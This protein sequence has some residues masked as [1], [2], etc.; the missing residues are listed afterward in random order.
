MFFTCLYLPCDI[1]AKIGQGKHDGLPWKARAVF[2]DNDLV[3]FCARLP[4]RCK[5]RPGQRKYLLKR[6]CRLAAKNI[7]EQPKRF[8]HSAQSVAALAAAGGC[9]N[10]RSQAV[11]NT[12]M[13]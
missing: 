13:Q 4:M 2:L 3:D 9:G 10:S 6:P 12:Q 11:G 5:Y 1:L 8:R 7:L